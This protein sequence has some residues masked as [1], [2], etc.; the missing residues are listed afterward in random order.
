MAI[1]SQADLVV[2]GKAKADPEKG[3]QGRELLVR[4]AATTTWL[5]VRFILDGE[6]HGV[7]IDLLRC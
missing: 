5:D 1:A 2:A 4:F 6:V 7:A 3:C